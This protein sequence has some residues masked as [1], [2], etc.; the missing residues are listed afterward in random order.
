[1]LASIHVTQFYKGYAFFINPINSLFLTSFT[2]THSI[3]KMYYILDV[4]TIVQYIHS[5]QKIRVGF[6]FMVFHS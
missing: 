1:M 2:T 5:N 3:F 4:E 6:S